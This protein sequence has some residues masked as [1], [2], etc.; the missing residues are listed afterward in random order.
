M[1][2]RSVALTQYEPVLQREMP[3]LLAHD[4]IPGAETA[5]AALGGR[6]C[7]VFNLPKFVRETEEEK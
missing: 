6:T 5:A 1:L 4:I 7:S 2:V 3:L